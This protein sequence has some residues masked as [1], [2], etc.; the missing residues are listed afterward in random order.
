MISVSDL[1]S[2][3]DLEWGVVVVV[4]VLVLLLLL[5]LVVVVVVV[6]VVGVVGVVGVGVVVVGVLVVTLFLNGIFDEFGTLL[7]SDGIFTQKLVVFYFF[8]PEYTISDEII[9]F[10]LESYSGFL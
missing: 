8:G 9:E 3:L 10:R 2:V 6:V 5:L 7:F 4:V 1:T